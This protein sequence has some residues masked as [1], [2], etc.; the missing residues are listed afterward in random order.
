[1]R[2]I[3]PPRG[4]AETNPRLERLAAKAWAVLLFER[5][6]RIILPP[7]W[8]VGA[9]ISI[10]WTGVWLD[11]PHWARG[12]GVLVLV[13][14]LAAAL[15]P[16]RGF[17]LPSRKEALLRID[18]VSGLAW[19][20]AAV[21]ADRLGIGADNPAT[22]TLW[23]LHRRR[24]EQALA[25][26]RAGLW[27]PHAAEFDRY[28][29]RAI[30]VVALIATGIVAGPEKY[31]RLAAAF[32]WR[33]GSLRGTDG[34]VDAWI[35]PPAYTGKMPIVLNL[36]RSRGFAFA[37]APK[38]IEA[39]IGSIVVVHAQGGRIGID[40]S[41]GL[42]E[43]AKG[44][45]T[46]VKSGAGAPVV[47]ATGKDEAE[48]LL[49]LGGDATLT[50]RVSGTHLGTFA[51]HAI[52]DNPPS[53]ALTAAPKFN[54]R[55][56][57]ALKYEVS[58][59]YGVTA[60]EAAFAKPIL[61]G[62]R[63]SKRTL[64]EPPRVPLVLPPPPNTSG[65]A[66]TTIDLSDHPWA[67]ARVELTL[68]AHDEGGNEG[69]SA[70]IEMT[71]PQKPFVKPLARALAEQRRTLILAPDDKARVAGALEALMIA[72]ETFDTSAGVYLGL[73]VALDRLDAAKT[74]NDLI[75]VAEL[76]WQMALRLES[77][78]LSAAERDLRAAEQ[79]LRDAMQRGASEEEIGKLAGNLRAAMD[80][81]LQELA[82][83]E[84]GRDRQDDLATSGHDARSIR[85]QDLQ[86]MVDEMQAMLRSG[87][88]ANAQKMLEQLQDVLENLRLAKPRKQD[89]RASE[90]SRALDELGHLSQDQQDLR[91]ETYSSGQEQRQHQRGRRDDAELPPGL[92]FGDIFGQQNGENSHESGGG[93]GQDG[94]G[95]SGKNPRP[96]QSNPADLAKRQKALRGRVETLQKRLDE[97]GAG[98][99]NLGEA[100]DAMRE[101]E[102]ALQQGPHGNGA[103]VEAQGRAVDAL[104]EG[105]QKLAD[106]LQGQGDGEAA[107]GQDEGQ[108]SPGPFGAYGTDPLGRPAG[109][110]GGFNNPAARFDPLTASAAE[111][112]RRVLEELRR[113]L[114]EP[115][116]PREELDYL[117][118]LLRR[119]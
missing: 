83:Q 94:Q 31:A 69:R 74:D 113:R 9:F 1:M 57:F 37:E 51:I 54:L 41:G 20:P 86:K 40:A 4:N 22:V 107:G 93:L 102:N 49:V 46:R 66:A 64:V 50:L 15:L 87:D 30:V 79:E 63:P 53:I 61:P 68:I 11:A 32:D 12:L 96:R 81:F 98:A 72:P 75:D 5:V 84:N 118:R 101:A 13:L 100:Q 23:T 14:G 65:E 7:L 59:D 85:Q 60:A 106:A 55:G 8:I 67:G 95:M 92:T 62:G 119:Y 116:R 78:D 27:S 18:Q 17:R 105:A 82:A 39:P 108:G 38:T 111:R 71:L 52:L 44:D 115:S 33:F 19:H 16:L 109:R 97:A 6:W 76:L 47:S 25:L 24:A 112:A 103:A 43:P 56:S 45:G 28:G 70:S 110:E 42:A 26:L 29:L 2:L 48:T 90:M 91:D 3:R 73:R 21:I 58:D 104:R 88:T 99:G 34:R 10:S 117:Q 77:G 36:S 80:K 89:P 35:D 114:G